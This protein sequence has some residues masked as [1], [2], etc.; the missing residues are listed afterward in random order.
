MLSAKPLILLWCNSSKLARLPDFPPSVADYGRVGL[1][2]SGDFLD[3]FEDATA[4]ADEVPDALLLH[5]ERLIVF[6]LEPVCYDQACSCRCALV[7][8]PALEAVLVFSQMTSFN[9]RGRD[10]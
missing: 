3:L 7:V 10:T 9:M 2:D 8:G 6:A 5:L 4:W 1:C